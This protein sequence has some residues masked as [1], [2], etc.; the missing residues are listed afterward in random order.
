MITHLGL[1]ATGGRI[2]FDG[3]M[4]RENT[5]R[6]HLTSTHYLISLNPHTTLMDHWHEVASTLQ[7]RK[8]RLCKATGLAPNLPFKWWN[9][10]LIQRLPQSHAFPMSHCLSVWLLSLQ[11][12][13]SR[14][15]S[16]FYP[17][18]G[19]GA[20]MISTMTL[21]DLERGLDSRPSE[22][23]ET[24]QLPWVS[25]HTMCLQH[26]SQE[27]LLFGTGEALWVGWRTLC[28]EPLGPLA[29][30]EFHS[31][32]KPLIATLFASPQFP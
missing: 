19:K 28:N 10:D 4:K 16:Y 13:C 8:L 17:Y 12:T 11:V 23:K 7:M 2:E 31:T 3:K 21:S 20:C 32:E 25:S 30:L 14:P 27:F 24:S 22:G 15:H 9:W 6:C 18:L 29:G 26:F 5:N 1:E